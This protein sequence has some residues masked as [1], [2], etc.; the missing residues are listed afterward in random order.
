LTDLKNG[1]LQIGKSAIEKISELKKLPSDKLKEKIE[2][3]NR[4]LESAEKL[5]QIMKERDMRSGSEKLNK[6]I[7]K[8]AA[9]NRARF[10]AREKE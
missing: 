8:I 1:K 10:K 3:R 4:T 5:L 6:P 7:S 9:A 2:P